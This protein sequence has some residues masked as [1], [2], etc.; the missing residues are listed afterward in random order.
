MVQKFMVARVV[1]CVHTTQTVHFYTDTVE[2]HSENT[3][4]CH[5]LVSH[6]LGSLSLTHFYIQIKSSL[7]VLREALATCKS[8]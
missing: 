6:L 7:N 1:I 3:D 5:S 8:W 4:I 2:R